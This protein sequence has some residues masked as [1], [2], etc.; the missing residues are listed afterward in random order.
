MVFCTVLSPSSSR[1]R[2]AA[3]FTAASPLAALVAV[4]SM[5]MPSS[6]APAAPAAQAP[7]A[8]APRQGVGPSPGHVPRGYWLAASDGG[9]FTYGNATFKG[10]VGSLNKPI[11]GMATT[12]L[13][14][15]YWLAASDGGIFAFHEPFLGSAGGTKLNKPVVAIVASPLGDGYWLVASDGGV[16]NYGVALLGSLGSVK[17]NQPV[18]GAAATPTGNGYWLVASDGGIFSFGDAAFFGSMGSTKLTKPIAGMAASPTG[19]GYWLVASDG[20]IFAFGDAGFYGSEGG[21]P[22]VKGVTGIAPTPSGLGYW[23]AASDGGVFSF[24]DATFFGS[25]GGLRLKAPVVGITS[26]PNTGPGK[27]GIFYYPWYGTP[28]STATGT[29]R[30][31]DQG[32]HTP[33]ADIGSTYYPARGPYSS[34]DRAVVNAQMSEIAAAGVNQVIVAWWGQGSY[35]DKALSV[36]Q[37][38]ASANGVE[39]AIHFEPYNGR[40]STGPADIA[41]L[42]NR[43][44]TVFYVYQATSLPSAFWASIRAQ[45]SSITMFANGSPSYT[46]AG[47]GGLVTYALLGGFDGIYT[48]DPVNFS[49]SDFP[50]LCALARAN[51]L[52]CAPSVAP[53]FDGTRAT[54]IT[55]IRSRQAGATYDSLWDGAIS[56][57][58]EIVTITSYNEWHEGTQI[59]PAQPFCN[60]STGECYLN[61]TGDFGLA[62]PQAQTGYLAR[63]GFWTAQYRSTRTPGLP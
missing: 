4:F 9:V 44:I 15:G 62:D 49:G 41:Y 55:T 37:A 63:T 47:Q 7:Q 2:A 48:Y 21:A 60:S 35:E 13:G 8:A 58:P 31:W 6:A 3:G 10:S 42:R 38:A 46:K 14:D 20:G 1:A 28:T 25:A 27:V 18:V 11:V 45:N 5:A 56:A 22:G 16:F 17:L 51:R 30:H 24:G 32:G 40:T 12:P 26:E 23:L 54:S 59:E 53:G 61:Y 52:Q 39:M 50:T 34:T 19:N 33:P 36:V 57:A 43:G 29:W